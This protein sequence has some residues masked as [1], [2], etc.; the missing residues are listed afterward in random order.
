MEHLP[1]RFNQRR[2]L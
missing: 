1:I 2:H